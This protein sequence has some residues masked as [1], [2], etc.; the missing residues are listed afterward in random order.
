[1]ADDLSKLSLEELKKTL[2]AS[3]EGLNKE[4]AQKRLSEYGYN[5]LPEKK[6]SPLLKFL[7]YFWGPIPWMIEIA[8]ILSAVVRHWPDFFIIST[9]LIM[10]ALIGF[11]EEYQAGNTIAALKAQL[12]LGAKVKRAGQWINIPARD[13]V[14]GDIVRLRIGDIIPADARLLKWINQRSR[15]N[16]SRS[17]VNQGRLSIRGPL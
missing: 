14:P 2:K 15:G 4:E 1:M 13:I 10:N 5:E 6:E 17:L 7:L 9:L 8:A 11:W 12:A 16:L 3:S